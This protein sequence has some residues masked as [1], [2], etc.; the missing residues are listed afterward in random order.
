MATALCAPVVRPAIFFEGQFAASTLYAWTGVGTIAWNGHNWLGIGHLTS[1]S[2]ISED[3]T[4]E[5]QNVEVGLSGIPT[6]ALTDA[7][8]ETRLLDQAQ[9]W[10]GCFDD[11]GAL[12][13][14]PILIYVGM[15]D[16]PLISDDGA[17]LT[18]KLSLENILVDLNR[19]VWRRYTADDQAMDYPNDTGFQHVAGIQE[20]TLYWGVSPN[21]SNR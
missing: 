12:V 17:E 18:I 11:N 8:S 4:V 13:P 7:L 9:M 19:S 3:S 15:M 1:F 21:G 6:D 14:D 10:L 20:I 2:A 16:A 5:A